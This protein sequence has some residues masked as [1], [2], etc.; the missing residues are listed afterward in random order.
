MNSAQPI[1]AKALKKPTLLNQSI[2]AA[3]IATV[4]VT[5]ALPLT[6]L[7][8]AEATVSQQQTFQIPAGPLAQSLNQF[9]SQADITLSFNPDLVRGQ[10]TETLSGQYSVE[11]GL[12]K[13]LAGKSLQ[14]IVLNQNS[15]RVEAAEKTSDEVVLPRVNVSAAAYSEAGLGPVSG[16]VAKQSITATKADIPLIETPQSVSIVTADQITIQNAESL[17]QVMKYT[18]GVVPMGGDNTSSDGMIIRGFNVTGSAPIYLNGAKLSRNTF[19]G[20]SE[21]YAMERIEIL[22]GPASVLYGNAAPGG[23]VNMVTKQ[24]QTEPLRELKVQ[25]G[26]F[27]RKQLAGDF[28]GA[29]TE[30]GGLSYRMT[31]LVRRSDTMTDYVPDDR[32]FV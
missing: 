31:G 23:I 2:K 21:P 13:L 3:L 19:S 22:K 4:V 9:A 20:V 14:I 1:Q 12:N 30:D 25:A 11:Q 5:A 10:Q 6:T 15:Y 26:S 28:A 16:Y 32:E 24:P 18:P 27:D 8:A 7:L 29:L 17:H